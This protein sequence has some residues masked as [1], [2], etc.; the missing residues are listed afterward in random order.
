ML[1]RFKDEINAIKE[2]DP[3]ARR[4]IEIF[5]CSCSQKTDAVIK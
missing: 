2:K 5:L 1:E 3:A 4:T